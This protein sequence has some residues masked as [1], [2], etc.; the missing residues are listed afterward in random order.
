MKI[1]HAAVF[2]QLEK[3]KAFSRRNG[4]L[5]KLVRKLADKKTKLGRKLLFEK[6][7]TLCHL[8]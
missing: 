7:L 3:E 4:T 1:A 8:F 5:E 6:N 2:L